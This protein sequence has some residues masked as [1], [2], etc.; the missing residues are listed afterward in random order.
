MR[1]LVLAHDLG[2]SGNKAC[3]YDAEGE[4]LSSAFV[5]YET[6]YPAQGWAEQDPEEWWRAVC[7]SSKAVISGAGAVPEEL[8]SISF[9][10][11]SSGCLPVDAQGRPL[12]RR[13][14]IWMDTRSRE[15]AEELARLLG[16][17]TQYCITGNGLGASML[18]SCKIMWMRRHEPEV[19]AAAFKFIGCKEYLIARMTGKVG[20]TDYTEAQTSGLFSALKRDYDERLLEAAGIPREKLCEPRDS[21]CC[22]GTVRA[23]AA[24][25]LGVSEKTLV[26]LG[27]MDNPSAAVGAGCFEDGVFVSSLGTAAWIACIAP[28]S[29]IDPVYHVNSTYLG[30]GRYRSSVNS[31]TAGAA[32]D[33]GIENLLGLSGAD[34]YD[35]STALAERSEPGA[36]GLLYLPS[37]REGN[38]RYTDSRSSGAL[39]G[40]KLEHNR[41][42][43]ARAMYEA[44]AYELR[45]CTDFFAGKGK[46]PKQI[47]LI[48]GGS[49][50]PFLAQV[51]AD[52]LGVDIVTPQNSRHIGSAGAAGFA[53]LG[54]GIIS[55][56]E[57]LDSFVPARSFTPDR[58]K[59]ALY[60]SRFGLYTAYYEAFMS[61]Y[62]RMD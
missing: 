40:L 47:R 4:L 34:K 23:Q 36:H 5:P 46:R 33:W 56:L 22:L 39:V 37:F 19:Y 50:N 24:R 29:F 21:T 12:R 54:A 52:V 25:E 62:S 35:A 2:T 15:E 3:L 43:I 58:S 53:K 60:D 42:D 11:Q 57:Q 59:A 45:I 8:A 27:M 28:E 48:G 61:L 20:I 51:I 14:I 6:Y 26:V 13:A 32:L 38:C 9:S 41:A 1:K 31:H 18:P 16:R 7:A 49:K 17:D 44:F 30:F 10:A 55:G